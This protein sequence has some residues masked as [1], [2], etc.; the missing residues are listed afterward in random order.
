M[1]LAKYDD[2]IINIPYRNV[3]QRTWKLVDCK[4]YNSSTCGKSIQNQSTTPIGCCGLTLDWFITREI[5]IDFAIHQLLGPL[6]STIWQLQFLA[7]KVHIYKR[8]E[9]SFPFMLVIFL[10]RTPQCTENIIFYLFFPW[11]NEK[12]TLKNRNNIP[13]SLW[14]NLPQ[15]DKSSRFIWFELS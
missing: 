13:L 9:S 15:N 12:S 7:Q 10:V 11:K 2:K 5:V 14:P 4:I 3:Y 1:F 8:N 6:I